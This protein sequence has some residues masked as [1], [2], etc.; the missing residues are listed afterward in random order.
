MTSTTA[1]SAKRKLARAQ[2]K[3]AL[4]GVRIA[5]GLLER[6]A[7]GLGARW[8][9]RLWFTVP[10]GAARSRPKM[11]VGDPLELTLNGRKVVG[12]CWGQ[13]PMVCLMHGWGGRRAQLGALVGPLVAAG[14]RVVAFD[15]PSHGDSEP[16]GAGPGRATILD[17]VDALAALCVAEGPAQAI[18]AHSIGCMAAAMAVRD[19]LAVER[20]VLVAPMADIRLY[21]DDFARGV[22]FGPRIQA[23]MVARIERRVGHPLSYFAIPAIGEHL[24]A[25]PPLLLVH[26][27]NDNETHW[28]DSVAIADLWSGARLETTVGLGHRRV[29]RDPAVISEIVGFVT[30]TAS[31]DR[32]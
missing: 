8:A 23:R 9:E 10:G 27:Q 28:S 1:S 2:R 7:P 20:L 16:G 24:E 31:L 21:T 19:G 6:T 5:F 30:T 13:G 17:F 14:H 32:S 11:P 12:E 4:A 18:V 3:A 22:G 25:P 15:A 26:D 29:L